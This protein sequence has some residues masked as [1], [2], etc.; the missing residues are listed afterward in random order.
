M[1]E[2]LTSRIF[3]I[4]LACPR[5]L[6]PRLAS[7]SAAVALASAKVT[8]LPLRDFSR[9]STAEPATAT[10]VEALSLKSG[11]PTAAWLWAL[12]AVFHGTLAAM[13]LRNLMRSYTRKAKREREPKR[14][15]TARA[16]P[17]PAPGVG[18]AAW[19]ARRATGAWARPLMN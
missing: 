2:G 7:V 14:T 8:D 3:S 12:A 18:E 16:M 13:R 9:A 6:N 17:P 15:S 11:S 5:L 19:R 1:R 10:R 4:A